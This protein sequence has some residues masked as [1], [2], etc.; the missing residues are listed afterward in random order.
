MR[1]ELNTRVT[2]D[3]PVETVWDILTDLEAYAEWNPFISESSGKPEVGQRL[4]NRMSPPGGKEMTFR[5][6][7]T[8]AEAGRTFEW[9]GRLGLPP[10][11]AAPAG[12]RATLQ[13]RMTTDHAR[14]TD[15]ARMGARALEHV[16]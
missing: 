3:A 7:V 16:P 1:H 10:R 4:T 15:G 13:P 8:E 12:S 6:T 11:D 2:I 14:P 5:P 9:L